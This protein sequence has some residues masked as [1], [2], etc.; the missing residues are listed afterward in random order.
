MI[1]VLFGVAALAADCDVEKL[2]S[3]GVRLATVPSDE[4]VG[5]AAAALDEGCA[6]PYALKRALRELPDLP[7][8]FLAQADETI[9]RTDPRRWQAA[10]PGGLEG[11]GRG[12]GGGVAFS[13]LL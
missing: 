6:L 10:C 4:R 3:S 9:A 11:A 13:S 5:A 7:P 1:A 8:Q 2:A 12:G